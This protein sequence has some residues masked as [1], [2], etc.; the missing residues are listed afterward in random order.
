M[1]KSDKRVPQVG[2]IFK[3]LKEA[4]VCCL[5]Y[6]VHTCFDVRKRYANKSKING[7]ITSYRYV[8]AKEGVWK[9]GQRETF[10]K[11]FRAETRTKCNAFMSL[12]QNRV[13]ESLK[14]TR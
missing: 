2:M 1:A 7:K 13:S 8:C 10:Q 11:C 6:G 12:T 3:Y 9:K 14:Y 4:W 5:A